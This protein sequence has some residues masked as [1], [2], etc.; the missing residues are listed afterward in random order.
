[1][2]LLIITKVNRLYGEITIPDFFTYAAKFV[3]NFT[4]YK[5]A[6]SSQPG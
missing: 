3:Y 2:K 4:F 5:Q 6:K 1:M